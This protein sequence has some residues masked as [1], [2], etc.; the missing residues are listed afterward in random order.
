MARSIVTSEN[1]SEYDEA[2]MARRAREYE[3]DKSA[4]EAATKAANDYSSHDVAMRKHK[5][6]S[7]YAH[8]PENIEKHLQQA[9][10]HAAEARKHKRAESERFVSEREKTKRKN[11]KESH[12]KKLEENVSKAGLGKVY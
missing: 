1:K 11:E 4:A 8:P 6:A 7:I 2:H 3:K 5:Q 9:K 10:Y 12:A